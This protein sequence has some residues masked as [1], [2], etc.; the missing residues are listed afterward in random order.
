MLEKNQTFRSFEKIRKWSQEKQK[1]DT[2]SENMFSQQLFSCLRFEFLWFW[3]LASWN[4]CDLSCL[5]FSFF[6]SYYMPMPAQQKQLID[7]SPADKR[8]NKALQVQREEIAYLRNEL[9]RKN[10]ALFCKDREIRNL[11]SKMQNKNEKKLSFRERLFGRR[12]KQ[13]KKF[14]NRP[15][16]WKLEQIKPLVASWYSNQQIAMMFGSKPRDVARFIKRHN[17]AR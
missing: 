13:T 12:K 4:L 6:I 1:K 11:K 17:L 16:K 9:W 14:A 8:W 7:P 15:L 3:L 2:V 10:R 5:S